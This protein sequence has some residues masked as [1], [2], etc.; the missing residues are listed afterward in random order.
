MDKLKSKKKLELLKVA[1]ELFW[2]YGFKRVTI[3]E[4]CQKSRCEQNDF[5]SVLPQ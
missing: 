5:L 1:R 2:Q 3:G 4:I